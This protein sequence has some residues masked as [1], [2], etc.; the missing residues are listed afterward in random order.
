[1]IEY[2]P[3]PMDLLFAPLK[4]PPLSS[5]VAYEGNYKMSINKLY[6]A[7]QDKNNMSPF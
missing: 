2:T 5:F 6:Q 3:W 1:M 7:D 4:S